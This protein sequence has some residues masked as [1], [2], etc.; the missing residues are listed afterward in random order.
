MDGLIHRF[1][2]KD[3]PGL[4]PLSLGEYESAFLPCTFWLAANYALDGCDEEARAIL[5]RV[6]S[7]AGEL[8]LFAEEA[9]G[10]GFL[11]NTPQLFSHTAYVRALHALARV[12]A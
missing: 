4:P 1:V 9:N 10:K 6:E 11:G 2:A 12:H 7:L 3:T 5:A 8:G